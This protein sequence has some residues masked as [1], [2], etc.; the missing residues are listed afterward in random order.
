MK[1]AQGIDEKKTIA[2]MK[3]EL[4]FLREYVAQMRLH[5][6]LDEREDILKIEDNLVDYLHYTSSVINCSKQP[7]QQKNAYLQAM[8]RQA[9]KRQYKEQ[10]A[11]KVYTLLSA[12]EQLPASEKNLLQDRYIRNLSTKAIQMRQGD[13][14][15]STLHRRLHRAYLHLAALLCDEIYT[16]S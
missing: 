1:K 15:E 5:S 16:H 13:I 4:L 6:M 7:R 2:H 8:E 11:N 9:L 14:V 3:D 10:S 12:M